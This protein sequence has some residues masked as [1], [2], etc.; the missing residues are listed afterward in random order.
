MR[1]IGEAGIKLIGVYFAASAV[2]GIA[3]LLASFALPAVEGLP[4]AGQLVA[5]GVL[6]IAG[7]IVVAAVC[8]LAGD[9][10]ARRFF[11]DAAIDAGRLR[12]SDLLIA[13][14]ALL[15]LSV[16]L[17]GVP[18]VIEIAAKAV[19][20]AEGTRQSMF[21]P[22]MRES[23]EVAVASLLVLLVGTTIA[24]SADWLADLLDTRRSE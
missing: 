3:N 2:L 13:G 7:S 20:Y 4:T 10:I 22:A 21:W 18:G 11:Q 24:A 19:W 8:L 14:V 15:G 9:T 17:S 16:A 1:H 12:R 23:S 6:S 5:S